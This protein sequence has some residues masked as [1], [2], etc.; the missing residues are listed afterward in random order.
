VFK[1]IFS[2]YDRVIYPKVEQIVNDQQPG[3]E[4][5]IVKQLAFAANFHARGNSMEDV[6]VV[7]LD[8]S[9]TTGDYKILRFSDSLYDAFKKLDLS[10]RYIA[11]EGSKGRTIQ[12]WVK[13]AE[14][15]KVTQGSHRLCQFRSQVMGGDLRNYFEIG[16]MMVALTQINKPIKENIQPR[17]R[18]DAPVVGLGR[19]RR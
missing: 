19:E 4:A 10:T 9:L 18:R 17:A 6:E 7:K 1:N 14:G 15:E 13:P 11:K 16:P 2:L 12:I 5:K 3:K 8:D